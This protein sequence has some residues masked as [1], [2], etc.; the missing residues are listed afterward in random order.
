MSIFVQKLLQHLLAWSDVIICSKSDVRAVTKS[1]QHAAFLLFSLSH[2]G[3]LPLNL[4]SISTALSCSLV[5]AKSHV[6]ASGGNSL[7][8]LYYI[9]SSLRTS[10]I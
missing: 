7:A 9:T 6:L 8:A 3:N 5:I 4:L 2:Q 10:F 1:Q